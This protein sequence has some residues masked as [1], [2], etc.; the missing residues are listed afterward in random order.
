M[1][2][3]FAPAEAETSDLNYD[4]MCAEYE[5]RE[6]KI[7]E[8]AAKNGDHSWLLVLDHPDDGSDAH[9]SCTRCPAD[10]ETLMADG[11]WLFE[12]EFDGITVTDGRHDAQQ[13][14]EV[15]VEVEVWTAK[16]WTDCGWEYD[17]GIKAT[18]TG[19]A[20]VVTE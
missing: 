2:I 12:M 11:T 14:M 10:A 4:A 3:S 1:K 19:P 18:K 6:R 9:L 7:R 16:Y 13:A 15:P 17:A 20:R 5:D 8:C